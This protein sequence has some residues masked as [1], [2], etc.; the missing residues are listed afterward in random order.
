MNSLIRPDLL[1]LSAYSTHEV[2]DCDKLDANEVPYALPEWLQAKLAHTFVP[3]NRY[4]EAQSLHLKSVL[5]AYSGVPTDW[6]SVG[7]GSDEI[8]RSL[9]MVNTLGTGR[10]VLAAEPTFGMY[11]I[12][13]KT[14]GVPYLPIG[15]NPDTF[16]L[17]LPALLAAC[18]TGTVGAIFLPHPNSPTGT[19]LTPEELAVL[20][21]LPQDILVVIDEAYF[22]FSSLTVLPELAAHPNWVILRTLSKAFRLAAYRVGYAIAQP[23]LIALL[24][25]VRLPYNVPAASQAAAALVV[26]HHEEILQSIPALLAERERVT[27]GLQLLGFQVWPSAGNFVFCTFPGVEP[28]WLHQAL[29]QQGTLV[30]HTCGALRVTM[31]TSAENSRL[32][33]RVEA[34]LAELVR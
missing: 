24:E 18:N 2:G 26:A 31:G 30:R 28:G 3:S 21:N 27:T 6:I 29:A 34:I 22:E 33:A 1:T 23:P 8:I 17:D 10:A 20:G 32:L 11:G 16:H 5:S 19:P 13:A 14:L 9:I 15:R 4:P 25:K 12:T 7:N